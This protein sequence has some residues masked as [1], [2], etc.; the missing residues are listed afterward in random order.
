MH[1]NAILSTLVNADRVRS[2]IRRL[3]TG[4]ISE[5][6]GELLQNSQRARATDVTISTDAAGFTY[7]DNGHGLLGGVSGFHTRLTIAESDFDNPTIN[8][9]NPMGLGIH[10]LLAHEHISTV[11]FESDTLA[12][13]IDIV[14]WWADQAPTT[15]PGSSAWR[16]WRRQSA[17]CAWLCS[18]RRR[19]VSSCRPSCLIARS[20]PI[21]HAATPTCCGSSSTALP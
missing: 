13:T 21:L 6:L 7:A 12:L 16:P 4:E 10:A 3:F 14:R 1:T 15:R 20:R 9:Q 8:D 5:I 17:V 11:R 19:S 18:A 2:S